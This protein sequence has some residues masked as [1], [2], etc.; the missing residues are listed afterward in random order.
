MDKVIAQYPA[1]IHC[2]SNI[3]VSTHFRAYPV[4]DDIRYFPE[5]GNAAL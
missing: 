2:L 3:C 4:L 1:H 5:Y